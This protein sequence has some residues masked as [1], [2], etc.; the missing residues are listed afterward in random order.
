MRNSLE[1][2]SASLAPA[3][4]PT[5]VPSQTRVAPT[6]APDVKGGIA[7]FR[8]DGV[9][10][11]EAIC[12][13]GRIAAGPR[14]GPS[15]AGLTRQPDG[16]GQGRGAHDPASVLRAAPGRITGPSVKV[17]VTPAEGGF[18]VL[19]LSMGVNADRVVDAKGP[20]AQQIRLARQPDGSCVSGDLPS[21]CIVLVGEAARLDDPPWPELALTAPVGGR[22]VQSPT[23]MEVRPP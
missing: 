9:L 20:R 8:N 7:W 17:A 10:R 5:A 2:T 4:T 11:K 13:G 19:G 12:G 1:V 15:D 23:G 22:G 21:T 6:V 16:T 18:R 3:A 14:G